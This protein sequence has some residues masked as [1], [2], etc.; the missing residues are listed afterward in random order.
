MGDG[1]AKAPEIPEG[2]NPLDS[3]LYLLHAKGEVNEV[4]LEMAKGGVMDGG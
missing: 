1:N 2:S 3:S 4:Q